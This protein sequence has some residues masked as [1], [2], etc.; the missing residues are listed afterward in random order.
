MFYCSRN[1]IK[2]FWASLPCTM[3]GGWVEP[4]SGG[5]ISELARS[6]PIVQFSRRARMKPNCF[7]NVNLGVNGL[8]FLILF[9]SVW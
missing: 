9:D 6:T 5:C 1:W 2:F 7:S 8:F 3:T 4:P